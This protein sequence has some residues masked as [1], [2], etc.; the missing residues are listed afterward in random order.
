MDIKELEFG[1]NL[2]CPKDGESFVECR[3]I[4]HQHLTRQFWSKNDE[5]A[6]GNLIAWVCN[7][8]AKAI[9]YNYYL[10]R[11]ARTRHGG[12]TDEDVAFVT[13]FTIDIDP[14]R[15]DKNMPATDAEYQRTVTAASKVTEYLGCGSVLATGNGCQIWCPILSTDI[16]GRRTW[17]KSGCSALEAKLRIM[18]G[19][20][21]TV[22]HTQDIAR[23][24]KMPGTTSYKGTEDKDHPYRDVKFIHRD[25]TLLDTDWIM[26]L[27]DE[28]TERSTSIQGLAAI[29]V[30]PRFW[31]V[32]GRDV[33]LKEA[34]LGQRTDLSKQPGDST[35]EQDMALAAR[36]RKCGFS[37][38]EAAAILRAAP[39]SKAKVREDYVILTINKAYG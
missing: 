9:R 27:A 17:W 33:A 12:S 8:V 11:S 32:L 10:G 21:V 14:L 1:L 5:N 20:D 39:N 29:S 35:S 25:V 28:E 24:V 15:I 16:R 2:L 36:C 30:P 31:V 19:Q 26:E 3:A 18:I 13:A 37:R 7:D 4:K 6:D 38:D 34:W 22:D 23:L